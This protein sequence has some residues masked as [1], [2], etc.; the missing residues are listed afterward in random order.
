MDR[1][2]Y[3]PRRIETAEDALNVL[4]SPAASFTELMECV[5]VA[6]AAGNWEMRHQAAERAFTE[7]KVTSP[8]AGVSLSRAAEIVIDNYFKLA[9]SLDDLPARI[10]DAGAWIG[11][12][13]PDFD[14]AGA[15]GFA[16][17]KKQLL[18]EIQ[19]LLSTNEPEA[20]VRLCSRLRRVE[21]PDLGVEAVRPVANSER[22]NSVALTTLGAAYC[23][24][25]DYPR[26]EKA[27]RAAV[28]VEGDTGLASVA[29]SRV[30]QESG[31]RH[32]ALDLAKRA[33]GVDPDQFSAHRLLSAAKAAEDQEAFDEAIREVEMAAQANPTA[34][35]DVYLLLLAAE[36]QHDLG[37]TGDLE[38]LLDR[39]EAS[40]AMLKGAVAKRFNSLRNSVRSANQPKLFDESKSDS[41]ATEGI[42]P[43]G[44]PS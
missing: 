18:A 1:D 31:R 2:A 40:P 5:E 41:T 13:Q 34:T 3:E 16:S 28:K 30:L 12:H 15:S 23:D 25:Q 26:A 38:L 27:L 32:E 20:R 42:R 22:T 21:R 19:V 8:S 4:R 37:L 11:M 17:E 10:A 29:L 35:P 43:E 39:I 6:N 44:E 7:T 33:F 36:A 14:A 24:L 9:T